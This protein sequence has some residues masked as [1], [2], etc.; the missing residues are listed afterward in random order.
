MNNK[1]NM[2]LVFYAMVAI[3]AAIYYYIKGMI[4]GRTYILKNPP[5][6]GTSIEPP[7]ITWGNRTLWKSKREPFIYQVPEEYK[8]AK[9]LE[10]DLRKG[11]PIP[12]PENEIKVIL[13]EW[14]QAKGKVNQYVFCAQKGI[15]VSTLRRWE[16]QY[17]SY[18]RL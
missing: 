2:L 10:Y 1:K 14:E 3:L 16:R 13:E 18:K 17:T 12:T 4:D 11:G 15:S 8:A 5:K 6:P 9:P 7:K